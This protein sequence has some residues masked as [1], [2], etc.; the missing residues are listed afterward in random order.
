MLSEG[1]GRESTDDY[2]VANHSVGGR[3]IA[4]GEEFGVLGGTAAVQNSKV[5]KLDPFGRTDP[6]AVGT[7]NLPTSPGHYS[8]SCRTWSPLS[9]NS[10][11]DVY[12]YYVGSRP[13]LV[14]P[15]E[16]IDSRANSA[17][18]ARCNL[19]SE[20]S[21]VIRVNVDVLFRNLHC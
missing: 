19:I 17:N 6:I 10:H 14:E 18:P 5:F 16:A 4:R 12:G 15:L 2:A 21:G 11:E 20:T 8:L 9:Q 7:M 13:Q 1:Y 3:F